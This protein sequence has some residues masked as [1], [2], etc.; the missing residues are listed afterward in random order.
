[1]PT[2]E[3]LFKTK[4]LDGNQTAE[5]K[6]DIRNSKDIP[7]GGFIIDKLRR[8]GLANRT[9]ETL[10]EEELIGLRAIRGLRSP[11]IYGTDILRLKEK[12]TPVLNDMISD[13]RNGAGVEVNGGLVGGILNNVTGGK[14][15]SLQDVK[16]KAKNVVKQVSKSLGID[17]PELK[18]PSRIIL[19]NDFKNK[20]PSETNEVLLKIKK[21]GQGNLPGQLLSSAFKSKTPNQ[22]GQ[23]IKGEAIK[24]G[25]KKLKNF[26]FG[27]EEFELGSIGIQ[28]NIGIGRN[29]PTN[30]DS[31]TVYGKDD[32]VKASN[33]INGIL[34]KYSKTLLP[35]DDDIKR[36][37]DLS[38]V[39]QS[40]YNDLVSLNT[41]TLTTSTE[42]ISIG[43]VEQI[44][45]SETDG[46][47]NGAGYR[48]EKNVE[49]LR[50]MKNGSDFL[51]SLE[52]YSAPNGEPQKDG[53]DKLY[54][55]YDFVPLR[56]Y[57]IAKEKAVN[58]RAT[59]TG[60]SESF[61]PEWESNKTLG[62]PFSY[63]TYGGV[64][65]SV[66][67]NFKI[68]SLNAKEH[69]SAWEKI[70][71]LTGLVYPANGLGI[72][73]QLFTTPPFLKITL[74]DLYKN[75]EGF[76]DSLTYN[77]DDN[78]PWEIGFDLSDEDVG[79]YKLPRIISVDMTFKFVE[80]MGESYREEEGKFI[81]NRF[82][83][84]GGVSKEQKT[85]TQISTGA[86]TDGSKKDIKSINV[87]KDNKSGIQS[88][89][90][91]VKENALKN[92]KN[93]SEKLRK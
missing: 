30:P 85:K 33:L 39:L 13:T 46:V 64:S 60:L 28:K 1:M 63:Y 81:A 88:D 42:F 69:K 14:I 18:I 67:F 32:D 58:F 79:D 90:K 41:A 17:F 12:S 4:K 73:G 5:Q 49:V 15:K 62:N 43:G 51:N 2:L 37:N 29:R 74:G 68:F 87:A 71:F 9:K 76:I 45:Y 27:S 91:K 48:K 78:T 61:A 70:N 86:N 8:S 23:N 56:F 26:L 25:K 72:S 44:K 55:D 92:V 24:L 50:G 82:Y 7:L 83:S 34:P 19:D 11:I 66:T 57:S 6:Y 38:Y 20:Q 65:R 84:F 89:I 80:T 35:S 53:A 93:L 10:I 16:Q 3:E 22:I 31:L 47:P 52:P 21:Q 77:I 75:S 54:E 36:K 59:I 40:R